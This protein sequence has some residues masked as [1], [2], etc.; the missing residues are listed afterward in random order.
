MKSS[1]ADM[2]TATV[3]PM[4]QRRADIGR[5]I[6]QRH[7]Y[8]STVT[9]RQRVDLASAAAEQPLL[10]LVSSFE[11]WPPCVGGSVLLPSLVGS[12]L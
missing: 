3:E 6:G 4:G 2:N 10:W 5:N 1:G 8:R 11:F 7:S 9:E 12:R